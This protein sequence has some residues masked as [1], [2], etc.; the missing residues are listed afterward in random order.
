MNTKKFYCSVFLLFILLC[1]MACRGRQSDPVDNLRPNAATAYPHSIPVVAPNT[2]LLDTTS[3][4]KG[5]ETQKYRIPVHR[6]GKYTFTLSS[7]NPGMIFVLQDTA[8]NNLIDE[9][10]PAWSG[11]L[12]RGD[13]TLIVG[14][15]RNAARKNTEKEVKYSFKIERQDTITHSTQHVD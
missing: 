5:Y 8:G 7:D 14:L 10:S 2:D 6:D 15:M 12:K 3:A 1:M 4:V 9:T 11:E 13:Y